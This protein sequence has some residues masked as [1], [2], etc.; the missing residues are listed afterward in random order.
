ME[1]K[2]DSVVSS[3]ISAFQKRAE[4][5]QTKYGKTLDR[6]DLTFLQWIQHAQE[7]LMDGILY[8]EKIK[9]LVAVSEAS[10]T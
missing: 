5:G 2:Y 10:H 3:V 1:P 8:L 7:E 4:I 6:N 9:T